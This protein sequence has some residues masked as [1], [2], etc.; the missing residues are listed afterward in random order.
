MSTMLI[1]SVFLG[2]IS[3]IFFGFAFLGKSNRLMMYI[4]G[5]LF[6]CASMIFMHEYSDHVKCNNS[7]LEYY[8]KK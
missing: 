2:I 6:F 4:I 1:L 8:I 3:V 7:K 5:C